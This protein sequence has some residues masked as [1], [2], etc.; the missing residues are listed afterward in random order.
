MGMRTAALLPDIIMPNKAPNKGSIPIAIMK[1][2]TATV[3]RIKW[4]TVISMALGASPS[5]I[6]RFM[7]KPPSKRMKI[8][9]RSVR[10]GVRLAISS[11]LTTLV[12]GPN[13]NPKKINTKMPGNPVRL[14]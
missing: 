14:N 8:M 6:F 10:Y 2:V 4:M 9:A 11:S 5:E 1:N 7:T 13:R 12:I 3:Q